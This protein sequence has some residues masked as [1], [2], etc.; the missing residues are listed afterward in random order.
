V[1]KKPFLGE[2]ISL[3]EA[4]GFR[5]HFYTELASSSPFNE[6]VEKDLHLDLFGFRDEPKPGRNVPMSPL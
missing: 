3:L 4:A 5:L 2:T 6:L 1:G